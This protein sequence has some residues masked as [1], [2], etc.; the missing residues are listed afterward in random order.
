MKELFHLFIS[1]SIVEII[2]SKRLMWPEHMRG[3]RKHGM[4]HFV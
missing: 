2:K 3:M 4:R 1:A